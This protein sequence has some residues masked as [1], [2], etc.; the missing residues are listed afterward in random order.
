MRADSVAKR[1][2]QAIFE[3]A[4]ENGDYDAWAR[5]LES[6]ATVFGDA[7]VAAVLKS[8]RVPSRDKEALLDRLLA[9]VRPLGKN[10]ARILVANGRID[11][12][13]AIR[14]A[15]RERLDAQRGIVHADVTSAVP[16]SEEE[17]RELLSRL[18]SMTGATV[19]L[20]SRVD[21]SILGGLIVRIGDRLI[22]GS[23]RAKLVALRKQLRGVPS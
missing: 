13:A 6:I 3:L 1:Y 18:S 8:V 23:T 9:D 15:Y 17:R 2:A 22:D 11:H 4:T 16:L 7:D 5:D 14:D 21:P 10:L 19:D 12:A 20:R